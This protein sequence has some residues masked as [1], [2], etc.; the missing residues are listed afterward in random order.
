MN[1][2]IYELFLD[3]L[4]NEKEAT[5]AFNVWVGTDYVPKIFIG[6]KFIGD[7]SS[8]KT[9]LKCAKTLDEWALENGG[10]SGADAVAEM[11]R[12][13]KQKTPD[14]PDTPVEPIVK[15]PVEP[16]VVPVEPAGP[17]EPTPVP[18]DLCVDEDGFDVI[19]NSNLAP[20]NRT[21]PSASYPYG[22]A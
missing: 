20:E 14:C 3:E 9:E 2:Y 5:D 11:D 4:D 19:A 21:P 17:P 22:T 1:A 16:P 13:T 12:I 7:Y 8:L 6:S 10:M 18:T 15:P